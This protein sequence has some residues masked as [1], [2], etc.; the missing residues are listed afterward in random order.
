MVL[1]SESVIV[2]EGRLQP[3]LQFRH[4]LF[5]DF[6]LAQTCLETR[7]ERAIIDRWSRISGGLQRYGCLRATLEALTDPGALA[8][9]PEL[10]LDR[11]ILAILNRGGE[12]VH[13]LAHTLGLLRPA[14]AI[15]PATWAV[16]DRLP[17]WFGREILAA[18]R[19]HRNAL[20]AE[21]VAA[22][23][24]DCSWHDISFAREVWHYAESLREMAPEPS[25]PERSSAIAVAR[26]LRVLSEEARYTDDFHAGERWLKMQAIRTVAFVDQSAETFAWIERE[27][28]HFTCRTRE[29][30]LSVSVF[31]A[32]RD[33]KR[34]ANIFRETIA[35]HRENSQSTVDINQW[36]GMM[37]H[38]VIEWS[39]NGEDN[40]RSLLRE[41]SREFIPIAL[42]L[43]HA[44]S[45]IQVEQYKNEAARLARLLPSQ[46][47]EEPESPFIGEDPRGDLID[48]QPDW[49][50]RSLAHVD[51]HRILRGI[52]ECTVDLTKDAPGTF[53]NEIAPIIRS[54]P[55]ATAQ[56]LILDM[57]IRNFNEAGFNQLLTSMLCDGRLFHIPG[58]MY[59]IE[60]GIARMW[61]VVDFETQRR[62]LVNIEGTLH[63]PHLREEFAYKQFLCQIPFADMTAEQRRLAEEYKIAGLYPTPAPYGASM[64]GEFQESEANEVV[65]QYVTEW[66]Q[67]FNKDL[68]EEFYKISM[69]IAPNDVNVESLER[70]LPRGIKLAQ[71]L[72]FSVLRDYTV[73]LGRRR[74]WLLQGLEDCLNRYRKLPTTGGDD[75]V[76]P[77]GFV[78][79]CGELSLRILREGWPKMDDGPLV[80]RVISESGWQRGLSLAD[81]AFTYPP[82]VANL[83]MQDEFESLITTA[84]R[85]GGAGI[86]Q[87][88]VIEIRLWHWFRTSK[89]RRLHD[90]LFWGEVTDGNVISWLVPRIQQGYS[91]AQQEGICRTLLQRD[92]IVHAEAF[93]ESFGQ[94]V[95]QQAMRVGREG[96]RTPDA[97]LAREIVFGTTP[98]PLLDLPD[99]RCRFLSR[100]V[101]GLKVAV[102]V[103]SER[104][105]LAQDYG[106]WCHLVWRELRDRQWFRKSHKGVMVVILDWRPHGRKK[107][108]GNIQ[109]YWWRCLLPLFSDVVVLGDRKDV[110]TLFFAFYDGSFNKLAIP[111]EMFVLIEY[112]LNRFDHGLRE[113]WINLNE[114]D[115]S[116][117]EYRSWRE[118]AGYAADAIDS[119]RRDGCL[120]RDVHRERAYEL[121]SRLASD[122]INAPK[123]MESLHRLQV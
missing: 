99:V 15:D 72:A 67:Y 90:E 40:H 115:P 46:F 53:V 29:A 16:A 35:L 98:F 89:R 82:I 19:F 107:V 104:R 36:Q 74:T 18:V 48:D 109:V 54:S 3:R 68:I 94:L 96:N 32:Q 102:K 70:V 37:D 26:K 24:N 84:F 97:E 50:W 10:S 28:P 6:A 117:G 49:Y 45:A 103:S 92:D 51:Y 30:V 60:Q 4:P 47:G 81:A 108:V 31:L 116:V 63:S 14:T 110:F 27:V 100:F 79:D 78:S 101:F 34:A 93:I 71:S 64:T 76:L 44:M 106:K 87:I 8:E 58:L 1:V 23:P 52:Q 88:V 65:K 42:D 25:S 121:L 114:T 41:H 21:Y 2:R 43:A 75:A 119:M 69:L 105:E 95:G 120:A 57:C 59:W 123:A 62:I 38:Y 55:L 9:F 20:W 111:E 56:S 118:I 91:A 7:E 5:R 61:Q 85:E 13:G 112:L 11:L 22:W 12:A 122:R 73:V 66:P 86:Q 77:D 17:I 80:G 83:E 39:L 113:G 33:P